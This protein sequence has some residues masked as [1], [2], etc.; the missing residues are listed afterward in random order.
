MRLRSLF[1]RSVGLRYAAVGLAA[2]ML[3]SATVVTAVSIPI[4]RIVDRFDA[5]KAAAVD[6]NGNV[7]VIASN[8]DSRLDSS[9]ALLGSV[10][11]D[12]D[13]LTFDSSGN[14][15]VSSSG[16]ATVSG[17]VSVTNFPATQQVAGTVNVGN[18]PATQQVAGTVN[19]GNLPSDQQIHGSVTVSNFP[20][21]GAGGTTT[22]ALPTLSN[23]SSNGFAQWY[24]VDVSSCRSFT[25]A[26]A[27]TASGHWGEVQPELFVDT[28]SSLR[29]QVDLKTLNQAAVYSFPV[30]PFSTEPFYATTVLISVRNVASVAQDVNG[31]VYCQH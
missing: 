5:N 28:A 14:L 12:A 6:E 15:K 17:S 23:V 22:I 4:T 11:S 30:Q 27:G 9:N 25:F 3:G 19:V 16:T 1:G 8:T 18:L 20:A 2:F 24:P 7:S 10:K 31:V 21:A 26:M 13:K 29:F